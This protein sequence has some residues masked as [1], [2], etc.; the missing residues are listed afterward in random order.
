MH[1]HKFNSLARYQKLYQLGRGRLFSTSLCTN[2]RALLTLVMPA[3]RIASLRRRKAESRDTNHSIRKSS[4]CSC[5]K[6]CQANWYFHLT[7]ARERHSSLPPTLELLQ[8][9]SHRAPSTATLGT[10][11]LQTS[12]GRSSRQC[13]QIVRHYVVCTVVNSIAT[14]CKQIGSRRFY[15]PYPET[16]NRFHS[17]QASILKPSSQLRTTASESLFNP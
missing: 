9:W 5:S 12:I 2:W 3:C 11:Q 8:G 15:L 6:R 7:N 16:I 1:S 14:R 13:V 17:L 10:S 4:S